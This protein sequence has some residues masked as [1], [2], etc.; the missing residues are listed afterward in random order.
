MQN[1]RLWS[2]KLV[3]Y[4]SDESFA[5]STI[6]KTWDYIARVWLPEIGYVRS[7][8]YELES[9]VEES[10]EFSETIYISIKKEKTFNEKIGH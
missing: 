4:S 1:C 8:G 3:V 5:I 2:I 7:G 6:H 9:Y 10:R